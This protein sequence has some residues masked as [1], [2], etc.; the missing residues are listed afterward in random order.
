MSTEGSYSGYKRPG[1]EATTHACL[2]SRLRMGKAVPPPFYLPS[3]R[4]QGQCNLT[5]DI[6]Q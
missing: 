4:S 6:K 2:E 3:W 1:C 5:F